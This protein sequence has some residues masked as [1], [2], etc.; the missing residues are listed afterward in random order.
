MCV[1]AADLCHARQPVRDVV[2][3][4]G[5]GLRKQDDAV[6]AGKP[7]LFSSGVVPHLWG[8]AKLLSMAW[9]Y[10]QVYLRANIVD[11]QQRD[12]KVAVQGSTIML[13]LWIGC[14]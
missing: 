3:C 10:L 11:G 9:V 14:Y 4:K 6:P 1:R 5:G 7:P 8:T 2:H 12:S 13:A